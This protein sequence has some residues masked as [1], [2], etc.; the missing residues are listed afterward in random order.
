MFI[1][2]G[3]YQRLFVSL[4]VLSLTSLNSA[5]SFAAQNKHAHLSRLNIKPTKCITLH[6]GRQCFTQLTINW[7]SAIKG[8]FCLFQQDVSQSIKCWRNTQGEHFLFE[9][10]SNK[11]MAFELRNNVTNQIIATTA[12]DV[13]WVHK[14]N[15]KKRQWRLF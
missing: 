15:R 5:T 7:H 1:K 6:Q 10:E 3:Y 2:L 4:F 8:D 13:S 11:K 14:K 9:F 12:V